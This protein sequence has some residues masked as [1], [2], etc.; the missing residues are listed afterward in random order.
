MSANNPKISFVIPVYNSELYLNK[1][2]DSILSSNSREIEVVL[3][4]DGSTDKSGQI[5]DEYAKNNQIVKVVHQK[6]S[7][8]ASAR[9]TGIKESF[10][11]YIFFVD[12]D[13][14]IDGTKVE[15]L[16]KILNNTSPD[17]VINKSL[18]VTPKNNLIKND[19]ILPQKINN[20]K[21]EDII[22]YFRENKVKI[23]APWQYTVKRNIL[24]KNKI[25]FNPTQAGVDDSYFSTI[26]FINCEYFY[27][28]EDIIYFWRLRPGSQGKT[29]D[30]HMYMLKMI[31]VIKSLDDY[32]CKV[33]EKYKIGYIYFNIYKNIYT[34]LGQYQGYSK[35]DKMYLDEWY[36]SNKKL[37]NKSAK[38]A[39]LSHRILGTIL[40]NFTG[41]IFSYK[42]AILKGKIYQLLYKNR[43]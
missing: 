34:L 35:K 26:L 24:I 22:N 17:I 5:C 37:I 12:N 16:I 41:T 19:F 3:I 8:V 43:V 23:G 39:G 7:G 15:N 13:D 20:K 11:D 2:V 42:F 10:G 33:N 27:L 4:N 29:H 28:N 31:S 9:N 36:L 18:V 14:W 25:S 30:R 21:P 6:N 1:C 32:T 40:G 38:Y